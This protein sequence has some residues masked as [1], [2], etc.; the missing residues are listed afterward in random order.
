MKQ[1]VCW[2]CGQVKKVHQTKVD[3]HHRWLCKKCEN[4]NK[5]TQ[6]ENNDNNRS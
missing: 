3:G 1:G 2:L 4:I 5:E 6:G